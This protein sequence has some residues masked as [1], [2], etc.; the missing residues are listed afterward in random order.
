[1]TPSGISDRLAE[2]LDLPEQTNGTPIVLDPAV[3]TGELLLAVKR[4]YPDVH[5]ELHGFD[6]DEG[7]LKTA[8]LN[9]PEGSFKKCSLFSEE[10]R[11]NE[12][13]IDYIIANPPYFEVKK[14][15][16]RLLCLNDFQTVTEKGRLNIFSFFFEYSL[17][18][19]K[20]YGKMSFLVPPSMNN[21]AYFKQLRD[22]ILQYGRIISLEVLRDDALFS[23]AQTAVQIIVIQKTGNS[24]EQNWA[25]STEHIFGHH[26]DF[27]LTDQKTTI[28]GFCDGKKSLQELGFQVKTGSIPWNQF[29]DDFVDSGSGV[30]LFYSKDITPS[31]LLD[32]SDKI[33]DQR[34]YL[35]A[36][37]RKPL[38]GKSI[39]VNRIVGSLSNPQIRFAMV[40]E[41]AYF[42]EN[43]VNVIQATDKTEISIERIYDSLSNIDSESLGRYLSAITGNTQISATE[44]LTK[45]PLSV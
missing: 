31:G 39:L 5:Y 43:H 41:P 28:T 4:V 8:V 16:D 10:W 25:D 26:H 15:D 45:L 36:T 24:Y 3:G 11:A 23:D 1:M 32:L 40:D 19:L 21:G 37:I 20:P 17:R 18:L 2:S 44:L 33:P 6:V 29:K 12:N 30:K 7:M 9:V 13:T 27:I 22:T 14:H 38:T 42:A 34:R 35:P